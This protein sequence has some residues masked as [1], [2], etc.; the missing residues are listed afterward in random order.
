MTRDEIHA[1]SAAMDIEADTLDDRLSLK[2]SRP[3]PAHPMLLVFGLRDDPGVE[4]EE[5][6]TDIHEARLL[7]KQ[8]AGMVEW[9]SLFDYDGGY[10]ADTGMLI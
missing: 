6:V 10:I 9:A 7:L 4:H 3:L 1:T 8:S 5:Y 2:Q